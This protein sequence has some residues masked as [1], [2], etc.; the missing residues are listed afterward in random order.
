MHDNEERMKRLERKR[1]EEGKKKRVQ[2][3]INR[4]EEQALRYRENHLNYT[5]DLR[6]LLGTK[7]LVK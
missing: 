3:K 4:T 2:L 7:R 1:S 6:R 5:F